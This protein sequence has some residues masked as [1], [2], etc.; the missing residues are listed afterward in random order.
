VRRR[1]LSP[2]R[3]QPSP[4]T[5]RASRASRPNE[6][7]TVEQLVRRLAVVFPEVE[8]ADIERAVRG[9]YAEVNV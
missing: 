5:A 4:V 8:P 7:E 3:R 6:V 2:V 9:Q 1:H